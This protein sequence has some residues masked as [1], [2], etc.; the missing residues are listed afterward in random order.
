M[1]PTSPFNTSGSSLILPNMGRIKSPKQIKKD[2][3]IVN[4]YS[5][6]GRTTT[7]PKSTTAPR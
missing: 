4:Q 5:D 2:A 1:T 6:S 3:T 7:P